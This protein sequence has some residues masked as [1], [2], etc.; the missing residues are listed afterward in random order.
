MTPRRR[1]TLAVLVGA[2][3]LTGC[4]HWQ[5]VPVSPKALVDSAHVR[6]IQIREERGEKYVLE[7]PTVV[8]DSL[9]GIVRRFVPAIGMEPRS[10]V[11]IAR[12]FPLA[13]IDR[14]AVMRL[15]G[16]K[17]MLVVLAVP[18]AVVGV[19]ALSCC[20]FNIDFSGWR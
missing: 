6:L 7:A 17:T 2:Q 13:T 14:V 20:R 11:V 10:A 5:V 12:T 8:G 3:L 1:L 16:W 4:T 9:R 19:F 15:S 18:A